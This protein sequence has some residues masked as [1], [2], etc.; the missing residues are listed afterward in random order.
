MA[1][2][3]G[4]LDANESVLD[5]QL[6]HEVG[7]S[8]ETVA[9]LLRVAQAFGLV[10]R[11][12]NRNWLVRTLTDEEASEIIFDAITRSISNDSSVRAANI[13]GVFLSLLHGVSGQPRTAM[14]VSTFRVGLTRLHKQRKIQLSGGTPSPSPAKMRVLV[15]EGASKAEYR[16]ID[17]GRG[18]FLIP[19][20]PAIVATLHEG[21]K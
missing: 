9:K 17:L 18:D 10:V 13:A 19:N 8:R 3:L 2:L 20:T 15:P 4:I 12:G 14:S 11:I 16:E 1:Q 5:D 6:Q 7:E 21:D